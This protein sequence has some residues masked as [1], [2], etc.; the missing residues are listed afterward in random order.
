MNFEDLSFLF[1]CDN[2]NRGVLRMNFDEAALLWRAVKSSQGSIL[3]VG[4]CHGGST[5]L[6][7]VA[8]APDRKVISVDIQPAHHAVAD[9]FFARPEI[10]A[11]LQLVVG[12]SRISRTDALGLIL[13]DGDHSYEGAAADVAAHWAQLLPEGLVVFHDAMPNNG[14]AHINKD[15]HCPGVTEVCHRLE[16]RGI[17]TTVASAGS[18]LVMKKKAEITDKFF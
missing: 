16:T 2:R 5:I 3:E 18:I 11:R 12:D 4:R 6:M 10:T 8:S 9:T 17:A 13:I 7:L 1:T 15:N 14:L